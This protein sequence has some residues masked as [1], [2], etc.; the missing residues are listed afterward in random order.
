LHNIRIGLFGARSSLP[1]PV[2][3]SNLE[4]PLMVMEKSPVSN[5]RIGVTGVAEATLENAGGA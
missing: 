2:S 1:L 5:C 4:K 3:G